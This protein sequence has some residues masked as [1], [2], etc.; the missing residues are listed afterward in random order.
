MGF[1][2]T[3]NRSVSNRSM[4]L[5]TVNGGQDKTVRRIPQ[6]KMTGSLR[7]KQPTK[8][9]AG[10]QSTW[11]VVRGGKSKAVPGRPPRRPR[12]AQ[13]TWTWTAQ[14]LHSTVFSGFKGQM[15]GYVFVENASH[16]PA[17]LCRQNPIPT[18]ACAVSS[19]PSSFAGKGHNRALEQRGRA[20]MSD[21]SAVTSS[22][23]RR[24]LTS[25]TD[26]KL[27]TS[28]QG[29][30]SGNASGPGLTRPSCLPGAAPEV[31][32]MSTNPGSQAVECR[33]ANSS[34]GPSPVFYSYI[35]VIQNAKW[36][37]ELRQR[38]LTPP[39]TPGKIK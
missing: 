20:H 15:N 10:N 29:I 24:T 11:R 9:R 39:N 14:F 32:L 26:A 34:F 5:H 37:R 31:L 17:N 18:Y 7:P 22:N 36:M 33:W 35:I 23:L 1:G 16:Q 4:C 27:S 8:S 3:Q 12:N 6:P 30:D 13:Q 38:K 19:S 25:G 28:Y 21:Q 2:T